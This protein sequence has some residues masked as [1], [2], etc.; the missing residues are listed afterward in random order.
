MKVARLSALGNGHLYPSEETRR[1][2]FLLRVRVGPSAIV[3]PEDTINKQEII[4]VRCIVFSSEGTIFFE[5][6]IC[7]F[8]RFTGPDTYLSL[9]SVSTG[10]TDNSFLPYVFGSSMSLIWIVHFSEISQI[11]KWRIYL[12]HTCLLVPPSH[13]AQPIL[14]IFCK[15][16]LNH[17]LTFVIYI[18]TAS[19]N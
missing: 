4:P 16:Y 14:S 1:H 18:I 13:P 9:M 6:K 7:Y 17:E 2:S 12:R 5:R 8:I 3:R 10:N 15:W 19:L 11:L